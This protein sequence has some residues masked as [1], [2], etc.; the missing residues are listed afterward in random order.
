M[1]PQID[2]ID[3]KMIKFSIDPDAADYVHICYF[4]EDSPVQTWAGG[5]IVVDVAN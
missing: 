2:K 5:G 3:A 1:K 4:R